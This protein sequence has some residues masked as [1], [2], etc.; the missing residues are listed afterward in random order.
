MSQRSATA[1]NSSRAVTASRASDS[2]TTSG[3][4]PGSNVMPGKPRSARTSPRMK[5]D[6][7]TVYTVGYEGRDVA[8][9]IA[10]LST[11]RVETLVDVRLTPISRKAG[12]SKTALSSALAD[13]GIT[14]LHERELGNPKENRPAYRAGEKTARRRYLAHL[15]QN[16][17]DAVARL[18]DIVAT[19]ATALLCVERE[20]SI[21]HRSA[22]AD[23]LG[24]AV[25]SL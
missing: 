19:S 5:A 6:P 4:L 17:G 9:L 7:L 24:V 21:C 23:Q 12:F 25:V 3:S 1:K 10:L 2:V 15:L 13:A 8:D 20:S 16:G 22:V 11:H 14:Y 18:S